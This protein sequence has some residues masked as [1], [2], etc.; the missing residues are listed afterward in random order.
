MTHVKMHP[1]IEKLLALPLSWDRAVLG[2]A[3]RL[4]QE[5]AGKG[6]RADLLPYYPLGKEIRYRLF[7]QHP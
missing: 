2:Q 5:Y 4:M 3:C 7:R 1:S 6:Y